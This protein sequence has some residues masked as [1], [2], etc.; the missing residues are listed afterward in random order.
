MESKDFVKEDDYFRVGDT[1]LVTS[2]SGDMNSGCKSWIV[3][4]TGKIALIRN[5][6]RGHYIVEF[7]KER[8]GLWNA[9]SAD[10]TSAKLLTNKGRVYQ[11]ISRSSLSRIDIPNFRSVEREAEYFRGEYLKVRGKSL[12]ML[13]ELRRKKEAEV[14]EIKNKLNSIVGIP[15]NS[16]EWHRNGFIV[17]RIGNCDFFTIM[18]KRDIIID[19]FV[20]DKFSVKLPEEMIYKGSVYLA[21]NFRSDG[22]FVSYGVYTPKFAPFVSFHTSV[23]S[24]GLSRVCIGDLKTKPKLDMKSITASLDEYQKL[25]STVNPYS[26]LNHQF[27]NAIKYQRKMRE[28]QQFVDNHNRD[29]YNTHRVCPNCDKKGEECKCDVCD[30]CGNDYDD[31][32]CSVCESCDMRTEYTCSN[33]LCSNCCDCNH[34]ESCGE[35]YEHFCEI[36][37]SGIECGCCRGHS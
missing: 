29:Y 36:C 21:C 32:E 31:C 7:D 23:D 25:L 12:K 19:S 14:D 3:G 20:C 37:N 9:N 22:E 4:E 30:V 10:S 24:I 26:Y 5:T 15:E 35:S 6:R 33:N 28:I 11:E 8:Q 18:Q 16:L 34:C 1:A 27:N 17:T 13:D 2:F